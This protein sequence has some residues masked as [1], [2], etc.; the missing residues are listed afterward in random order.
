L[1]ARPSGAKEKSRTNRFERD[2]IRGWLHEPATNASGKGLVITH[3]AGSNCESPLLR[4]VAETFTEAGFHVLRCN[5]PYRQQR[6]TGP[7]FPGLA[8]RDR[9]GLH[10]AAEAM[11][12]LTPEYVIVGGHSYGGRQA[13]L[14]AA[15]AAAVADALLLLS[16]P[17]HP[18]RKPEQPRTRHFP[19][20]RTPALFIH[21]TCDP[22]GSIE[23][24]SAALTAI[25]ARH[26][27]V[28]VEKA[29]HE[30][31]AATA[32]VILRETVCFTNV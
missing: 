28:T 23:K 9:E 12:E 18:P 14:L 13:T 17:L 4:A 21:G 27:L 19:Q 6:P 7:P 8:E 15:E 25:P 24:M 3:G 20:L 2:L 16:Y 1:A 32:A 5:L 29:G 30:L 26:Q 11:R 22:F 31:G 10:R